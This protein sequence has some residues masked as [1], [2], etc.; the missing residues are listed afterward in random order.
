MDLFHIVNRKTGERVKGFSKKSDAK[1]ERNKRNA[2]LEAT[3]WFV[4]RGDDNENR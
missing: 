3:V 1:A 4:T 2:K